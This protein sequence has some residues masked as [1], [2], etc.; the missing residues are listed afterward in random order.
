MAKW[1]LYLLA[2]GTGAELL[3]CQY[4]RRALSVA[5]GR[6]EEMS[7]WELYAALTAVGFPRLA[8]LLTDAAGPRDEVDEAIARWKLWVDY[9]EVVEVGGERRFSRANYG[10]L[11]SV[12][13]LRPLSREDLRLLREEAMKGSASARARLEMERELEGFIA[14]AERGFKGPEMEGFFDRYVEAVALLRGSYSIWVTSGEF[15]PGKLREWSE[16]GLGELYDHGDG[17]IALRVAVKRADQLP[18][19]LRE[20]E[21]RL[22][23]EG[24]KQFLKDTAALL[25]AAR[26]WGFSG[27]I[28]AHRA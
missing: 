2:R 8:F 17:D 6:S 4:L 27:F 21:E 25:A 16:L 28:M 5:V 11:L 10:F 18:P 20:R 12:Y 23:L 9:T 14:M 3:P 13:D 24:A 7:D 15:P 19:E 26:Y 1:V 22:A